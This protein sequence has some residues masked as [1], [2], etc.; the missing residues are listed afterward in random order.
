M[1]RNC[2]FGAACIL[3]LSACTLW[4]PAHNV[5]HTN[6]SF[7]PATQ[8]RIRVVVNNGPQSADFWRNSACYTFRSDKQADRVRVDDGFFGAGELHVTSVTIGMPP[9]PRDWMRP[10][11]LTGRDMI[12]EY[13]VDGGKP[14]TI[15]IVQDRSQY[16]SGCNPPP[17]TFTPKPGEDYDAFMD[18]H[19]R[20]CSVGVRRIG[21][22]GTDGSVDSKPA[23]RCDDSTTAKQPGRS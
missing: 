5:V 9:S 4:H 15:S 13:V 12:K 23:S 11:G 19:G 20:Y 2:T 18:W 7:D 16:V 1:F 3:A 14:L 17:M 8:A 10:E 6:P 21:V 22:D